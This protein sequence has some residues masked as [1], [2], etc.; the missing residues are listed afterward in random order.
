MYESTDY[1]KRGKMFLAERTWIE[2]Y[3]AGRCLIQL[4]IG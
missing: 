4:S 3:K 1:F 2:T